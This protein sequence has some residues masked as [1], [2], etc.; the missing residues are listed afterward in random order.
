MF[1]GRCRGC[2]TGHGGRKHT[3]L[4]KVMKVVWRDKNFTYTEVKI[5][6]ACNF[7]I[8]KSFSSFPTA[9]SYHNYIAV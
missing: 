3:V 6:N 9:C 7:V 4:G 1:T 2:K 8:F 5:F